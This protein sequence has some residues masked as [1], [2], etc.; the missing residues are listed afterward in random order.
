MENLTVEQLEDLIVLTEQK[1]SM[2]RPSDP[3][4]DETTDLIDRLRQM[5][6]DKMDQEA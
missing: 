5:R 3:E 6:Q 4:F 1:L 2:M